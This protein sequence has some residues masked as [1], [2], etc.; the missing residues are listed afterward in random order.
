MRVFISIV[1]SQGK[2]F[3]RHCY[4]LYRSFGINAGSGLKVDFPFNVEGKGEIRF[5]NNVQIFRNVSLRVQ[6]GSKMS[7]GNNCKLSKNVRVYVDPTVEFE[8]ADRASIGENT[9]CVVNNQWKIGEGAGI[10]TNC[11]VFSREPG[12][13]GKLLLGAGSYIGDFTI[14]D[15]SADV[16]IGANVAVGPKCT[17]YTHDHDYKEHEHIAWKGK[18]LARA[19][20]IGDGAWIGSNV[21]ILPGITIG[22]RA[23]VATGAVVTKDIPDGVMS[24]GIP[25]K[26]IKQASDTQKNN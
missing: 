12:Y 3:L 16:I 8:M 24:A 15:L 1:K 20:S 25:A 26:I 22:K 6:A 21:T 11:Q 10:A 23:I 9:H 13:H 7:V 4:W 14:V 18:P 2:A 5:G 17:I 19:I